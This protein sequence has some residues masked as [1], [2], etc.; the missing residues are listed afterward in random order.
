MSLVSTKK[1]MFLLADDQDR[2]YY[3]DSGVTKK[4]SI[5]KWLKQNPNGWKDMS[6][7]FQTN[8][9]YFATIRSFSNALKFIEDG[10]AILLDR[11][12][13]GLGTEEIMYLIILS[14]DP[15]QGLNYYRMEYKSRLDFSKFNGD[16]RTGI[17]MNTLQSDVF[18]LVQANE[19]TIYSIQCN[20]T[21]EAAIPI[22][23]DGILLQDKLNYIGT[24]IAFLVTYPNVNYAVPLTFVSQEGDS[25]GVINNSQDPTPQ[26]GD[27]LGYVNYVGNQN[28]IFSRDRPVTV[29]IKGNFLLTVGGAFPTSA[30]IKVFKNTDTGA[31]SAARAP[32]MLQILSTGVYS[33][34][35]DFSI[36]LLANETMF[37]IFN[38]F[39]V[40]GL[41]PMK[42]SWKGTNIGLIFSSEQDP[43]IAYGIRPVDVL[44]QL[45]SQI[46]L[47]KFTADSKF[48][49][50]N[51]R[52]IV[53]SGSSLRSFADA[54]I[55]TNF[56]DFFQSF[57][58]AYNLGIAIRN[59]I[60]YLEPVEDIYNSLNEL[61]D[62]GNISKPILTVA[63]DFI[64]GS[65]KVGYQKQTYN[66][67]NGRYEFNCTHTYKFPINTVLGELNLVSVYRADSFG[68]EFI[69]TGYPDLNSTDDKGDGDVFVAMISDVIGTAQGLVDN[70]L[71]FTVETLIIAAPIIKYP[72]TNTT[73]ASQNPTLSGFAQPGKL[74]TIYADGFVDGTTMSDSNGH[75]EYEIVT[76]LRPIDVTFSGLHAIEVTAETDPS[77]VSD[78]SKPISVLINP[79]Y[80]SSFLI[81]S[82][83]GGESLYNNMPLI[84]GIAPGA[85]AINLKVD[86]ATV[87]MLVTDSSGQW[88][89]QLTAPLTNGDH[90]ITAST[91]GLPN[92]TIVVTISNDIALPLITSILNGDTLFNNLPLVKGIAAPGTTVSI[93]LDGG[94]GAFV[95][96]IQGPVGTSVADGN[97]NWSFQF[98]TVV[99]PSTIVL[100]YIPD[101]Q[102]TLGTTATPQEIP[103]TISGF[104]LMRGTNKGPVMDYD[105]I[106]LDDSYVPPGVDPSTLPPTLGQFLHPETLYNIEESSPYE[107]M[108]TH[109]NVFSP[110]LF[111]QPNAN[112]LFNGA[113][114]NANLTRSKNGVIK[115]E[116]QNIPTPSLKQPLFLP[117]YLGFE[118]NVPTTFNI[119]M[120]NL[121]AGGYIRT[122]ING[123]ELFLL[124]IG[125][126]VM[127]PATNAPQTFKLLVSGKTPLSTLIQ[128]FSGGI[129]LN[130]GPNMIHFSDINPLHKVKYNYTPAPGDHFSDIYDDWQKNR[131][132]RWK[133]YQPDYAQPWQIG[134]VIAEQA[135]TN[136]VGVA[137]YQMISVTTGK[138]VD[139]FPFAAVTSPIQ[140]PS[141]VMECLIDTTGYAEDDYW[142]A[143]FID[144]TIVSITE[145]I[146]LR[147]DQPN[148]LRCRYGGSKDRIDYYF[149]T[150]IMPMIRVEG[151]L[152]LW[153]ADSEVDNYE[154]ETGDFEITRGLPKKYRDV[155][156]GSEESLLADWMSIKMNNI[157][158]LEN[159]LI[160]SSHYTR[161]NDSKWDPEDFGQG[162]PEV[163]V[164]IQMTLSE[165][166]TGVTFSTPGDSDI[167]AVAYLIDATAVGQNSGVINVTADET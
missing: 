116:S 71:V 97:G 153:K 121:Q 156:F 43:S 47:G 139:V 104:R 79:A 143:L 52:K 42:I 30:Q 155:Q 86:G 112:I 129:T 23:F 3:R 140:L 80:V 1:L 73:V 87:A 110:F 27:T 66:K 127:N 18:A 34:P 69:R 45:V 20:S 67:R 22:L 165:N 56:S 111:Q 55:Q 142:F 115:S 61:V 164:K 7:Q 16:P 137:E 76:P 19:N 130:I 10:Q 167:N 162:V 106:K 144:G 29:R 119:L 72:F 148:T 65:V 96:L 92:A 32:I 26:F 51:N 117:W 154:D 159:L 105:A 13:N 113:E 118:A 48:L 99:D 44:K 98:V 89:F 54:L 141:Q 2:T 53:L 108:R 88:R 64:Y 62:L 9:K 122:E 135:I 57:T 21:N 149:S 70:T 33:I 50:Q 17:S 114:V 100:P 128:L 40:G 36:D 6:F 107:M 63:E 147:T 60:L 39:T 77:N 78:F 145:K 157:T 12:I 94:G 82:P 31:S 93:F 151:E 58:S 15:S 25:V 90:T 103:A 166:Q 28:Y 138:Q 124:P 152:L 8:K 95:G 41:P 24:D 134:D 125:T 160:E 163:M 102:H 136:G 75:W 14:N 37:I 85:K 11:M 68:M 5:P 59:G 123:L 4:S 46:T 81:A 161:N 35:V 150:G 74:I 83:Y 131:F 133:G 158:L 91:A 120:D 38:A 84:T 146:R 101:G 126:M 132:P 49:S 109:D